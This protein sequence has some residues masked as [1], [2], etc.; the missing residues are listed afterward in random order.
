ME[1]FR[2]KLVNLVA[3]SRGKEKEARTVGSKM[4]ADGRL[5]VFGAVREAPH[6]ISIYCISCASGRHNGRR[7]PCTRNCPPSTAGEF[8]KD[9]G[10]FIN[11]FHRLDS[12]GFHPFV[13]VKRKLEITRK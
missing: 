2:L 3:R 5:F 12:L 6:T 11:N 13:V 8:S 7:F 1:R 9:E 4:V 10:R